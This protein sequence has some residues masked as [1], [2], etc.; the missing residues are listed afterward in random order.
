MPLWEPLS[1]QFKTPGSIM[2]GDPGR[3]WRP[4]WM[5]SLMQTLTK[6][7]RANRY[8]RA[9]QVCHLWPMLSWA[10]T[11][12]MCFLGSM[13]SLP[14]I[15]SSSEIR[16]SPFCQRVFSKH[17]PGPTPTQQQTTLLPATRVKR[18]SQGELQVPQKALSAHFR[19]FCK[20]ESVLRRHQGPPGSR[21]RAVLPL[22]L[23][24]SASH[25]LVGCGPNS[26]VGTGTVLFEFCLA[27][28]PSQ[29]AGRSLGTNTE[30]QATF[31][32]QA[33]PLPQPHPNT[34]CTPISGVHCP[35][36]SSQR[37]PLKTSAEEQ[38]GLASQDTASYLCFKDFF[39]EREK[40]ILP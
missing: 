18:L 19:A 14:E 39:K 22:S 32:S 28:S 8:Q 36:P 11:S 3:G 15:C 31:P 1:C 20:T 12:H 5:E 40:K 16:S 9:A 29:Q 7:L 37:D 21:T 38:K 34:D 4:S 30:G 23:G 25:H 33:G 13:C 2:V 26:S 24:Q 27:S 35:P 10:L 17:L 6:A